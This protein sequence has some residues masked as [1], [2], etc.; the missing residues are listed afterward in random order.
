MASRRKLYKQGNSVVVSIAP[1]MLRMIGGE[2]HDKLLMHPINDK[3]L[4][5]ELH[6]AEAPNPLGLDRVALLRAAAC[7]TIYRQ[8]NAYVVS[9]PNFLRDL[10]DAHI[11]DYLI[12]TVI[13]GN[14]L[15]AA[16]KTAAQASYEDDIGAH[17]FQ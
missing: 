10:I 11:G 17:K 3:T 4:L 6:K 7:R 16:I 8:G 14:A 2:A 1:Y 5:F 15:T 12:L 13:S 9:V